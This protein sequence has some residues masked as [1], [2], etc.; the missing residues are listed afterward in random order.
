MKLTAD[1][2]Q[3]SPCFINPLKERQLELRY[4]K[5]PAIENL[6]VTLDQ[7]DA[8][9]L[10]DNDIRRLENFPL[11]R[12]MKSLFMANNRISRIAPQLEESL[13]HLETLV[14]THNSLTNLGDIDPLSTVV[15][16]RYLS[17][18]D[19]PICRILYYRPYVIYKL[20]FLKV[21]DFKKI[22]SQE[23]EEAKQMFDGTTGKRLRDTILKR[24]PEEADAA[25]L[26]A[27]STEEEATAHKRTKTGLS[28]ADTVKIQEAIH[29]AKS[30]D[31]VIRLEKIL[32]QGYIPE[33]NKGNG[34]RKKSADEKE[35]A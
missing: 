33:D 23:R 7:Y 29:Q 3:I 22:K 32:R 35:T 13:P 10:S 26:L 15:S 12:R 20:P 19:N 34:N 17:F 25:E 21:L 16:L 5:I 14:L 9:D 30:L 27:E 4:N 18:I 6:G 31:E 28:D 2:I 1:V 8:I 11:M 24:K